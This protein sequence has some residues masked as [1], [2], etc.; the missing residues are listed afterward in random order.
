MFIEFVNILEFLLFSF[1]IFIDSETKIE[2]FFLI[3]RTIF[4]ILD[5]T[6]L[7]HPAEADDE[8]IAAVNSSLFK[9]NVV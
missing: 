2:S 7:L 1:L 3:L 6:A 5:G 9:K 8:S 4:S